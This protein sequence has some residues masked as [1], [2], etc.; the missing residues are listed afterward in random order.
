MQK[1]IVSLELTVFAEPEEAMSDTMA[2]VTSFL[3]K[4][5]QDLKEN[6][7]PNTA[8]VISHIEVTDCEEF[9]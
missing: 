7:K 8:S 4:L 6:G 2:T 5:I 3:N 1:R 9:E